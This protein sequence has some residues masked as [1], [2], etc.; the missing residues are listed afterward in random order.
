MP[1]ASLSSSAMRSCPHNLPRVSRA[2]ARH[3]STVASLRSATCKPFCRRL[4]LQ[5]STIA[6]LVPNLH[7]LAKRHDRVLLLLRQ[8]IKDLLR[9][10]QRLQHEPVGLAAAAGEALGDLLKPERD[11]AGRRRIGG[12]AGAG[13]HRGIKLVRRRRQRGGAGRLQQHVELTAA[14]ANLQ[15]LGVFRIDDRLAAAGTARR[16][17]AR[18]TTP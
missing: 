17:P 3:F 11:Q 12:V 15:T 13:L 6:S 18:S 4:H 14:A 1:S 16:W 10:D 2:I 9:H 7:L 8:R 5:S